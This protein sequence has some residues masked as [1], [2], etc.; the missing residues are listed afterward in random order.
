[1]IMPHEIARTHHHTPNA[2]RFVIEG[3]RAYTTVNGE[4]SLMERGDFLTTPIW[5]WRTQRS[6]TG[7]W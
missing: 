5:A 7:G 3:S 6:P 2:I 4:R 1:M